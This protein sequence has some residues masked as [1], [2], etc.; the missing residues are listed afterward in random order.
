MSRVLLIVVLGG[1]L[2]ACS[3]SG[4]GG[5]P[6]SP[7]AKTNPDLDPTSAQLEV[8]PTDGKLLEDLLPPV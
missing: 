3:G 1:F 4:G 6:S 5:S 7:A 8:P 2:F